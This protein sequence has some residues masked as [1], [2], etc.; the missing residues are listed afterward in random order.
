MA[1]LSTPTALTEERTLQIIDDLASKIEKLGMVAPAIMMLEAS[2]P[3]GFVGSQAL[4]FLQPFLGFFWN[5]LATM[6]YAL[7]FENR[8]NVESLIL[9][10][11]KGG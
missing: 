11:E 7:L 2:K 8:G 9:R 5:E 3:L 4:L 6:E 1:V 10:L